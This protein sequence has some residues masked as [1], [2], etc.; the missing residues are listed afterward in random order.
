MSRIRR[1]AKEAA[2]EAHRR[3]DG[4]E[5]VGVQLLRHQADPRARD[6]VLALD[7]GAVH[8]Q[9]G[10]GSPSI[11]V[12]A[13]HTTSAMSV[14]SHIGAMPILARV[15]RNSRGMS[16]PSTGEVRV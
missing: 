2:A 5:H 7:V 4:L 15:A 16:W 3:P 13:R 9:S 1:A 8:P 12:P 10:H 6:A 14:A 11:D